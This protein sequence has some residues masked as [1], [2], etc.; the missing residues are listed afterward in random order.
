MDRYRLLQKYII[1]HHGGSVFQW[2][3]YVLG[4][5]PATDELIGGRARVIEDVLYLR[6][7]EYWRG[8]F[9]SRQ[10]MQSE[11]DAL[12]AW[13]ATP[14]YEELAEY[15]GGVRDCAGRRER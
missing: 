6:R 4:S 9:K 13:E 10:D 11:L 3:R 1:E 8:A 2:Y 5:K 7:Q 14:V 15:G 12:P